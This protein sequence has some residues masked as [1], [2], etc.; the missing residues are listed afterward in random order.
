MY[1]IFAPQASLGYSINVNSVCSEADWLFYQCQFSVQWGCLVILSM[2]I[3]CA[4]RLF[5][6]SINVNSVRLFGYSINVNSVC[7]EAVWLFYQCQFSVQWGCLVILS[8]SIQWGCLVILSMSIQCA[9][10][11]FGYSINV[12][13]VCSEAVWLF[14]QCQFSEAVWLFYQCQFSVQWGCLVILSM[15]IQCAVRLFGYSINVNSVRLFGYSINVNSVCSEA[16]WL[17]YQCQFSVQWGCL[18]ILSMSIQCA[19]RLFG[20]SINV[21][22]VCSEAVW[23]FY[24]C[25]FSVQWGCLVILSMSMQCTVRLFD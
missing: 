13:S 4:V 21:N 5:G 24:Q 15:S 19:V 6:Y 10:R 25:Q 1:K 9:V 17:F 20:Y 16:V 11:L 7:S 18:V 14:Y 22:S 8:M 2:S 23:L 3:Q 12:N